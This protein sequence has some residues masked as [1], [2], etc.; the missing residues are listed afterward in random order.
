MKL[1]TRADLTFQD[2][3][4]SLRLRDLLP[5]ITIST[6]PEPEETD[7]TEKDNYISDIQDGNGRLFGRNTGASRK[8]LS[9]RKIHLKKAVYTEKYFTVM[10]C[11]S[12]F[13][14]LFTVK[15]LILVKISDKFY[16]SFY[17]K[18]YFE[19]NNLKITIYL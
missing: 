14:S 4:H 6:P 1:T 16:L 11:L 8:G 15:M 5:S 17:K 12:L 2:V 19:R 9:I 10:Y 7:E 18:I 3:T 13:Q